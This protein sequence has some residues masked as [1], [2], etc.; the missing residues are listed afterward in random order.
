MGVTITHIDVD[1]ALGVVVYD[2]TLG[3]EHRTIYRIDLAGAKVRDK[4]AAYQ[5]VKEAT[6]A[7][8]STMARM[9]GTELP[10]GEV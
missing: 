7:D 9:Y 4:L 8:L 5:A 3:R 2:D 6:R 1:V 10:Q